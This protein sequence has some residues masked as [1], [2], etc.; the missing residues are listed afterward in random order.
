MTLVGLLIL[1][2]L[3]FKCKISGQFESLKIIKDLYAG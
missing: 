2:P 3:K 1:T